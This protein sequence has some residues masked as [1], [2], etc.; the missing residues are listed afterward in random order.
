MPQSGRQRWDFGERT[1][2]TSSRSLCTITSNE[3]Y[4][5]IPLPVETCED[6]QE[7]LIRLNVLA[8]ARAIGLHDNLLHRLLRHA[9]NK[10]A[11]RFGFEGGGAVVVAGYCQCRLPTD[12]AKPDLVVHSRELTTVDQADPAAA[13]LTDICAGM[14][15]YTHVMEHCPAPAALW[16]RDVTSDSLCAWSGHILVGRP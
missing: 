4:H 6:E 14:A 7:R 3:C 5:R 1:R 13:E 10:G 2:A 8:H 9:V 12:G 15:T 16:V 11:L